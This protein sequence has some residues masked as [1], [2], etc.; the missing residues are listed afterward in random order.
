[1]SS[2]LLRR[3]PVAVVGLALLAVGIVGTVDAVSTPGPPGGERA[4]VAGIV[5][6]TSTTTDA[7]PGPTT[8]VTP[9]TPAE[10]RATAET[11]IVTVRT[12][13]RPGAPVVTQLTD[14]AEFGSAQTFFVLDTALDPSGQPWYRVLLPIPPNGSNGWVDGDEVVVEPVPFAVE[15]HL[16]EFRLDVVRGDEVVRSY[17]IGVGTEDTPTPDGQYYVKEIVE[18]TRTDSAYGSHAL[19]LNGFSEVLTF[20]RGGGMLGIHGTNRPDSIGTNASHGCIRMH[21]EDVAEL[22]DLLTRG[23]PVH[24][25]P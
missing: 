6:E 2:R 7:T 14:R 10:R 9:A 11:P 24:V 25:H 4:R 23:T 3:L 12:R 1:M 5:E 15:I 17:P 18:L 22:A 16:S 20:W 13:P 21:N 19:V 8:T